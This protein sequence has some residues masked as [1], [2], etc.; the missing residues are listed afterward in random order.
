MHTNKFSSDLFGT[1]VDGYIIEVDA[2]YCYQHTSTIP[3]C[4]QHYLTH[5]KIH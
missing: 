3:V 4:L 1:P 5:V 2:A